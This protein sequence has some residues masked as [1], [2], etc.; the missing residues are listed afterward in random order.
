MTPFWPTSC[1][2]SYV[3]DTSTLSCRHLCKFL[4]SVWVN[5]CHP[6]FLSLFFLHPF[7][8]SSLLGSVLY[9][10]A[11]WISDT[12]HVWKIP[13][14]L[15]SPL[16]GRWRWTW[17]YNGWITTMLRKKQPAVIVWYSVSF[18]KVLHLISV[19][20]P[21]LANDQQSTHHPT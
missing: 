11:R 1:C 5:R 8:H 7:K 16:T 9:P 17:K 2:S 3:S 10:T 12:V 4:F 6:T 20:M 13:P 15:L 21:H 14:T 18:W 19:K